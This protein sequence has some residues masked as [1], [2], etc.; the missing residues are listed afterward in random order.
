MFRILAC[1]FICTFSLAAS[2][3]VKDTT[4]YAPHLS[5]HYAYQSAAGDLAERFRNFSNVGASF[6]IKDRHNFYYGVDFGYMFGSRVTEPG[7][8]QNLYTENGEILDN[9]GQQSEIL[10]EGRGFSLTLNGGY[11]FNFVGPN[12]NSGILVKAGVGLLQHKIRLEHQVNEINQLD[13][14]YVKGYDRMTNGLVLS[15]FLGYYYM[16]NSRLANFFI[17]VEA[18]QGFT[19]SRRGFNFDTQERDDEQRNDMLFGA[20]VGWIIHL[21]KRQPDDYY[22]Y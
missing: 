19:Q 1:V 20:K 4:V 11:L 22:L 3:Q 6:S 21:R 16:S 9:Q 14:D 17:G 18:Y 2:G 15:Q 10:V 5:F 8:M 7:L 12:P 13:G